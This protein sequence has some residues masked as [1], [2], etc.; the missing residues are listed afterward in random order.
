MSNN[1]KD[2]ILPI[3]IYDD[4]CKCYRVYLKEQYYLNDKLIK[5]IR[6][7]DNIYEAFANIIQ[8]G[9]YY[10]YNDKH[11]H[12]HNHSFLDIIEALYNYPVSF[13]INKKDYH[14]YSQQ[15]LKYLKRLQNF[16][17][18]LN[19]KDI[20]K[21]EDM[22]IRTK[23]IKAQQLINYKQINSKFAKEIIEG[24]IKKIITSFINDNSL[25]NEDYIILDNEDNYLGIISSN[26]SKIKLKDLKENDIDYQIR[27]YNSFKEFIINFKRQNRINDNDYIVLEN[28]KVKEKF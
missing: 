22:I 7:K 15:E 9:F 23:N 19:L 3:I 28:L 4:K 11:G 8:F 17:L 13:S 24:K 5:D 6:D 16:L 26:K 14:Y 12:Q 1:Y 10:P 2:C 18:I 27:N 21:D 25:K 20:D